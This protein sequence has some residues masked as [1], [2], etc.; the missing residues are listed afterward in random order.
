MVSFG[1]SHGETMLVMRRSKGMRAVKENQYEAENT[2]NPMHYR[3]LERH[4][5]VEVGWEGTV[6][7]LLVVEPIKG[8]ERNDYSI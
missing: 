8:T 2:L 1:F 5:N 7:L 6:K 4:E 3:V